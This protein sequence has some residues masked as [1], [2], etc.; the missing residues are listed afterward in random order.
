[1]FNYLDWEWFD[2]RGCPEIIGDSAVLNGNF[3]NLFQHLKL[4]Q[5][6]SGVPIKSPSVEVRHPEWSSAAGE[7]VCSHCGGRWNR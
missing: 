4:L 5:K 3:S 2:Y 7:A 6:S 1:M